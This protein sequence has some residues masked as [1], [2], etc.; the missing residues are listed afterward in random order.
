[1]SVEVR[2][3]VL[4]GTLTGAI[5]VVELC[6]RGAAALLR[7]LG[8]ERLPELGAPRRASLRGRGG[9]AIDDAL[10]VARECDRFELGLHGGV[11]VREALRSELEARGV[12]WTSG[13]AA[14]LLT[15]ATRI[16][17]A[18]GE[19]VAPRPLLG[20]L[21]QRSGALSRELRRIRGRLALGETEQ[22]RRMLDE[23]AEFSARCAPFF[24]PRS[25]A[26]VGPP[27]AGKS[28]CFNALIGRSENIVDARAGSTMDPVQRR[29]ALGDLSVD[30]WDTAGLDPASTGLAAR[31]GAETERRVL[32]SDFV[33]WLSPRGS[34][35]PPGPWRERI[36]AEV[37]TRGDLGPSLRPALP[38][39]QAREDPEGARA[40]LR[41][42]LDQRWPAPEGLGSPRACAPDAEILLALR[43]AR[44]ADGAAALD[45]AVATLV[46]DLGATE[47]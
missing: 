7:E 19:L 5:A 16:D 41:A 40:L 28:T 32:R 20:L 17:R 45:L 43:E 14:P 39:L 31:A 36:D 11:A 3:R 35:P 13:E 2:A 25:V 8:V 38:V 9:A 34:V 46:N 21:A 33:I 1:M 6:G 15:I 23:L 27:N 47:H 22:A 18:A 12:C 30:L 26:L 44:D 29:I 24:A 42:L 37:A 10:V 4:T